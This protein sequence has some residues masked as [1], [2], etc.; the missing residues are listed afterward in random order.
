MGSSYVND[1]DFNN[2]SY[3]VYVQADQQFRRN[4][5]DLREYY[6]RSDSGAM[7]PLDNLVAVNETSGPQVIYHYNLFRSA[8]IDGS[9]AAGA[10]LPGRGWTQ[11]RTCSTRTSCR[12]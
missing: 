7:V 1:F 2:R 8:E 12:G 6:V 10:C 4:A 9:P 3:R 5:Q 11:W